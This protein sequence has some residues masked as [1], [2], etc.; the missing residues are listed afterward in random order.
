MAF[1]LRRALAVLAVLAAGVL[2]LAVAG[3][4]PAREPAASDVLAFDVGK[5]QPPASPLSHLEAP[6]KPGQRSK[7][8]VS[9]VPLC[10]APDAAPRLLKVRLFAGDDALLVWCKQGYSLFTLTAEGATLRATRQA[11]FKSRGE[12]PGGAAAGDFDGDG[13]LD[14]ALGVAT[15][16]GVVHRSGA[17]VFWV[18]G[19]AQGGFEPPRPLVEAPTVALAAH[20]KP[21]ATGHDLLVLTSGDVAAQ[22]P[23]EL[24]LF[25]LQPTLTRQKV[26]PVGLDPRALALRPGADL[27]LLEAWVASGQG[28]IARVVFDLTSRDERKEQALSLPLRGAQG[29]AHEPTPEGALF[30]RDATNVYQVRLGGAPA[31]TPFAQASVGPFVVTDLDADMKPDVLAAI[32]DGVIWLVEGT[33]QRER[34]LP[35]ELKVLDVETLK[36]AAGEQRALVLIAGKPEPTTLSL[37]LLPRPPWTP[38][39]ELDLTRGETAEAPGLAEVVLE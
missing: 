14:L 15:P 33:E 22:R 31:L 25:G 7:L 36:D 3:L 30:V 11:R 32:E 1:W 20:Q 37:L 39:L 8:E 5:T 23:G 28:L 12:L 16:P 4:L 35:S 21:G 10:D 38:S 34:T 29:F 9:W 19:R 17:G 26:V 6:I 24:W 2:V 13:Q 18:R 27:N